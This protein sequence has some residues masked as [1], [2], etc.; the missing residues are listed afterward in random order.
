MGKVRIGLGVGARVEEGTEIEV[1]PGSSVT[2]EI[3]QGCSRT[4]GAGSHVVVNDCDDD[5]DDQ[6][7]DDDLDRDDD[8][9]DRDQDRNEDATDQGLQQPASTLTTAGTVLGGVLAA[10]TLMEKLEDDDDEEAPPLSP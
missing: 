7:R 8:D 10:G 2:L 9:R 3:E 5:D 1:A 4:F 6:D